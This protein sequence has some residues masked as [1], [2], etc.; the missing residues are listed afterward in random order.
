MMTALSA[1]LLRLCSP[2]PACLGA[3]T[4]SSFTPPQVYEYWV[5]KRKRWG[6]PMM[7]RLQAPTSAHDTDPHHTFRWAGLR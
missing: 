7:K 1:S 2:L 3:L 4:A 5:G 6:K